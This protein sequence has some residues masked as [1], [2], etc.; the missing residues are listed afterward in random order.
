[1]FLNIKCCLH[2][3][4]TPN[5]KAHLLNGSAQPVGNE[6]QPIPVIPDGMSK[7]YVSVLAYP[8]PIVSFSILPTCC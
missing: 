7:L 3:I 5:D 6:P 1:M 2:L 8:G 4:G